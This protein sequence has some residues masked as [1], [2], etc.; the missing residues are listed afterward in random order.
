MILEVCCGC[1]SS[2]DAAV[3]GGARRIELCS[4]LEQDGLTPAWEDLQYARSK[5]P[6][7]KIHVLIRPRGGIFVYSAAEV[8]AMCADIDTALS[9]GADGIVIGALTT[10]GD[11]D[12]PAMEAMMESVSNFD[13]LGSLCHSATDDNIL[14]RSVSVTFHRAFDVCRKPFDALSQIISLG[15]SRVL[16]SGQAATAIEGAAMIR[17][18]QEK[19]GSRLIILAGGGVT[20]SNVAS[21]VRLSGCREVHA[22]A[23]ALI[24]GQK[25]T[26]STTVAAILASL[27]F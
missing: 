1:R 27:S 8:A 13:L 17:A 11:V 3:L 18:L 16:T 9:L 7:L 14:G 10:A 19:A 21:L 23:S 24:D 26:Q 12:V 2:V 22:S 6:F 4:H 25:V 15:C 5:Y 20:P